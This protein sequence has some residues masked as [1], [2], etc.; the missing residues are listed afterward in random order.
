MY[1]AVLTHHVEQMETIPEHSNSLMYESK[2]Q[3]Y[4]LYQVAPFD[5]RVSGGQR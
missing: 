2:V 5:S 1:R 3:H 4:I